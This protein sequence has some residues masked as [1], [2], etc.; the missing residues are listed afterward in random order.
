M[1]IPYHADFK[2]FPVLFLD[3][4]CRTFND[5][6]LITSINGDKRDAKFVCQFTSIQTDHTNTPTWLHYKAG[7]EQVMRFKKDD[8]F[9][10][11]IFG[12]DGSTLPSQDTVFPLSADPYKQTM[13]QLE[14]TDYSRDGDYRDD[15]E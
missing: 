4:H 8:P 12:R 14:I 3:I 7:V 11:R 15:D 9:V 1:I 2:K 10:I 6:H 13:I 5:V